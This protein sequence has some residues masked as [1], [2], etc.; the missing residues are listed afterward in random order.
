MFILIDSKMSKIF[1]LIRL[2]VYVFIT[3]SVNR[4]TG[5]LGFFHRPVFLGVKARC[6]GNWIRFHSEVK[7]VEHTYSVGALRKS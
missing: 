7:G 6:F 1:F 2:A 4:I 3:K 5:F